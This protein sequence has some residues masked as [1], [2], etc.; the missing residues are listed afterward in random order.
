MPFRDKQT[1]AILD[2]RN[3][4]LI[5]VFNIPLLRNDKDILI[6]KG[7]HKQ[8]TDLISFTQADEDLP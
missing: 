7:G 6:H 3:A 5:D 8:H 1:S 2:S 4:L